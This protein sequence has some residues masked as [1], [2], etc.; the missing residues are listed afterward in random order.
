MK[1]FK[2]GGASVK[3]A[4]S[5]RNVYSILKKHRQTPL[6]VVVSAMGK[7]TN[8]LEQLLSAFMQKDVNLQKKHLETLKAYHNN[9][10]E[11]LFHEFDAD[12]SSYRQLFIDLE[13]YLTSESTG[14]YDFSYAQIVSKGEILSS[15]ILSLYLNVIGCRNQFLD[16]KEVIKTDSNYREGKVNWVLTEKLI[17][18]KIRAFLKNGESLIITQGFIGASEKGFPTTLGR[19]GSDYSA[20]IFAYCLK[21]QDVTIWKDVPGLLNADPKCFPDAI[22]LD[23]ISYREAIELTYYGATVIHPKTLKPLQNRQIPLFVKS[24]LND[25]NSGTKIHKIKEFKPTPSYIFKRNQILISISPKDFSFIAE[26]SLSHIF[27]LF[28]RFR[29]KINF[30]QNSALSFTVCADN[31]PDALNHLFKTLEDEFNL[32][33][34]TDLE[35][36]TIRHYTEELVEKI[37]QD[38]TIFAEQKN[39]TT[40]QLVVGLRRFL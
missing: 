18:T 30:M 24:F 12:L 25:E 29:L 35:L 28:A 26:E 17:Q 8:L 23:E 13:D 31:E 7:T 37:T 6:L 4:E 32:K 15:T 34:N 2:F 3:D 11:D 40:V 27:A 14:N 19:E 22:K 36:I 1:V 16:A 9:I 5:V 38:K 33:Y 21:A 10:I 20:A 39:R